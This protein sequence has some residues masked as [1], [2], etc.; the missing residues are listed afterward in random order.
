MLLRCPAAPSML[1]EARL[2]LEPFAD[3][4]SGPAP[5]PPL[6]VAPSTMG[7]VVFVFMAV[8]GD[9]TVS[10]DVVERRLLAWA[11]AF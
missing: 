7:V 5:A 11:L 6:G 8:L 1:A 9:L 4:T 2:D 3:R 10:A